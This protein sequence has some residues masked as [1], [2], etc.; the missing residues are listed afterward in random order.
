MLWL[1]AAFPLLAA[2]SV[3]YRLSFP[4]AVHHEVEVSAIFTGISQP[5]LEVVMSRSSPGRYALHEFAKNVYHLTATGPG[6]AALSVTRP[7]PYGWNIA[8]YHG[9]VTVHYTLFGDHADGTYAGID[10]THAHLNLPATLVWAHGFENAPSTLRFDMPAGSHWRA[11]TQLIPRADGS[12]SAP[13]LEWLM[14]SPL[15]LSAFTGLEWQLE[16]QRFRLALHDRGSLEDAKSFARMCQ[17]VTLEA[18]GVFGSFPKFDNGS[19]TFLIDYLPYVFGDGMEHRDSTSITSSIDLKESPVHALNTVSHEFFHAWNVRRIR[20][21]SLEPF[22]FE[23]ANMSGELWF[24]EGFTSYYGPLLIERAGISSLDDLARQLGREVNRVL[25]APGREIFSVVDMSRQAPFVDAAKSIDETNVPNT[26]ISY[27]TYGAA[28][29]FGLDLQIRARFPGKSLDDWMRVMWRRHPD[30]DR[31]YTLE[32]LQEALSEATG[33]A[34]FAHEVFEH[35]IYGREPLD[36]QSLAAQ[37]GL[38]L[39]KIHPGKPWIGNDQVEASG[40]GLKL[41]ELVLRG[42]PFYA[43]GLESGDELSQCDGKPLKKTQD[44]ESCLSKHAPGDTLALDYRSRAGAKTARVAVME[45]PALE[46]VTF[47]NAGL[48][49]TGQIKAF[50]KAWLG[51]R[52]F[53]EGIAEPIVIW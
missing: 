10:E 37:A 11:A 13:N 21:R 34:A 33:S 29:A 47:E 50:R 53:H 44:L 12:W 1:F 25:N 39:R 7:N 41:S 28:L 9:S 22:D 4:N 18:E 20:P 32:D 43:A 17:S 36:Y 51:S 38:Q 49:L 35:H 19:Y 14:D 6:G 15:E 2:P 16:N 24:A 48:Q 30:I 40:E 26:F 5:L 27:Y 8:G 31:P 52:S 46:I 45:D 42:S 3:E 23:R